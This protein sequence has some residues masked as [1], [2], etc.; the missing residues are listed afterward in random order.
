MSDALVRPLAPHASPAR[1][2][3]TAVAAALPVAGAAIALV[4]NNGFLPAA[5]GRLAARLQI[6]TT[7]FLGIFI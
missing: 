6:F 7:I 3:T 2:A 4:A 5:P 1:R